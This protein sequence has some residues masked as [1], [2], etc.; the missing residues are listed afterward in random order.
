M[1]HLVLLLALLIPS[2]A[3]S[4]VIYE[5]DP[6]AQYDNVQYEPYD[7]FQA[8]YN[9]GTYKGTLVAFEAVAAMALNAAED[10]SIFFANTSRTEE[11]SVMMILDGVEDF[12]TRFT[13]GDTIAVKGMAMMDSMELG[14]TYK[15]PIVTPFT[16]EIIRYSP[17][18]EKNQSADPP[19]FGYVKKGVNIRSAPDA[20][21][22]KV[23]YAKQGD[24][25]LVTKEHYV[26]NWHQ[27]SINGVTCYVSAK[28]VDLDE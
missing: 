19:K 2:I 28:Y 9:S 12:E 16:I 26:K 17:L 21:S 7:Y 14:M 23:G 8:Y 18:S 4:Q 20:S 13:A 24:V 15:V 1:K 6:F 22:T 3:L 10:T 11:K 25:L 5:N 27:I